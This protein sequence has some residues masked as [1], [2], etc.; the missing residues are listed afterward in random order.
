MNAFWLW[1]AKPLAPV[2]ITIVVIAIIGA[3]VAPAIGISPL[4]GG[5]VLAGTAIVGAVSV[6]MIVARR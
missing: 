5:L 2:V 4:I 1:I 3:I 6:I